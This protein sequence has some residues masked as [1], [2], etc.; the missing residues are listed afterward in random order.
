MTV[1]HR[2]IYI[3]TGRPGVLRVAGARARWY[4]VKGS[5]RYGGLDPP[6]Q[7][8]IIIIKC[9]VFYYRYRIYMLKYNIIYP[10]Q[11]KNLQIME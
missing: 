1:L 8:Y 5:K 9:I 10:I 11:E 6:K 3:S 2:Y 7:Y 4:V